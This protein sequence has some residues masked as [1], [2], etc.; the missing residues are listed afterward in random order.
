MFKGRIKTCMIA[1][2]LTFA[3][4]QAGAAGNLLKNPGFE[5]QKNW[6]ANWKIENLKRTIKPYHY[7]LDAKG[8]GHDNAVPHSGKT[9]I[10]I[11]CDGNCRT[12]LSQ[13]VSLKPGKYRFGIYVRNN[14]CSHQPQVE[15]SAGNKKDTFYVISNEYRFYYLDFEVKTASKVD[16][17]VIPRE[18]GLAFDDASLEAFPLSQKRPYLFLD[19]Y[20][21]SPWGN[22]RHYFK[23]QLQWIDFALTC[24]DKKS[25]SGAGYM[26]VICPENIAVEGINA[27]LLNRW[28]PRQLKKEIKVIRKNVVYNGK[29]CIEYG[30]D[31]PRFFNYSR[32]QDFG[33]FWVRPKGNVT[34]DIFVQLED[35]GKVV[36]TVKIP[37]KPLDQPAN[38]IPRRLVSLCYHVQFWRQCLAQRLEAIPPQFLTMGFNAWNDYMVLP[39]KEF[40]NK[41]TSDESVML[42]AYKDYGIKNFY[43][44]YSQLYRVRHHYPDLS[45]KT[46]EKDVYCINAQEKNKSYNMRFMAA[47]GKAWR[48]SALDYWYQ[49]AKRPVK[50]GLPNYSGVINNA[51]ESMIISYDPATLAD[52]AA[53]RNLPLK[54]MTI[55]NLN[56]KYKTQWM[57]YNQRLFNEICVLWA[58]KM[59]EAVP[60]IKTANSLGPFGPNNSRMLQPAD[61][62]GWA[63]RYYDYKMP[64][65]Y[66]RLGSGYLNRL[67]NG[68]NAGLYGKE[69]GYADMLPILLISMGE[70]LHDLKHLRFAAIDLLSHSKTVK[71]LA[72]YMGQYAFADAKIML[73]MSKLNT[74]IAKLEDYFIDGKRADGFASFASKLK[75]KKVR[76]M[77]A[78]GYTTMAR[79]K[80]TTQTRLHL[81]NKNGRVALVTAFSRSWPPVVKYGDE[82]F[83]R[84]NLAKLLP[85]K[86]RADYRIIDWISGKVYPCQAQIF[87]NTRDGHLGIFEIVHASAVK[88]LMKPGK[89]Q[90]YKK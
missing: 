48:D 54:E 29:K 2:G 83:V 19:L 77:D 69:K 68:L 13:Q 32:P 47:N 18:G 46:G 7:K 64:Q 17:G 9:A 87:L 14:G 30:F 51:Q 49:L 55:A 59:R 24:I 79:I 88:E 23:G 37:L 10:E 90:A 25:Y 82:G 12:R 56:G 40:A 67:N 89:L 86:N 6:T 26:R 72:Y 43:F 61:R 35:R 76:T 52:F 3:A 75:D 15:I 81:L 80:V 21:V 38:V 27:P 73:E 8:G 74:L 31:L 50:I 4:L 85:G 53:Q 66:H 22:V 58:K 45:K 71:G 1:V 70:V 44:T 63:Q 33:G 65:M 57:L 20:P 78:A 11:Y 60:G 39:S 62:I 36:H 28:K 16:L 5:D 41:P 42:K 84:F 34:G